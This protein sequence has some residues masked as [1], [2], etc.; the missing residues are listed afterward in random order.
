MDRSPAARGRRVLATPT[1]RYYYDQNNMT[2]LDLSM[3]DCLPVYMG[4]N[5]FPNGEVLGP[6]ELPAVAGLSRLVMSAPEGMV[7]NHG[8]MGLCARG[9]SV[10]AAIRRGWTAM[11]REMAQRGLSSLEL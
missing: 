1:V 9:W 2:L 4:G 11:A 10:L 6:C 7:V 3:E 5:P 8:E